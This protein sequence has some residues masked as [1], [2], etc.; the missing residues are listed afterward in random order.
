MLMNL[1]FIDCATIVTL[2]VILHN[3]KNYNENIT[4]MSILTY[5][6]NATITMFFKNYNKMS[7]IKKFI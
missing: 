6:L 7:L 1:P 4:V 3:K 5:S 2:F